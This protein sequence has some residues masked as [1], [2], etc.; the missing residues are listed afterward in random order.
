MQGTA[1]PVDDA[2]AD[3]RGFERVLTEWD[4]ELFGVDVHLRTITRD[5]WVCT[6]Y[7]PGYVHDGTEGEL[8]D[9]ADDPL[10]QVNRWDDPSA[11]P[12]CVPTCSP[13]SGTTSH[14]CTNRCAGW[15]RR[16]QEV[17]LVTP[18]WWASQQPAAL[19]GDLQLLEPRRRLV[20]TALTPH[21]RS[22]LGLVEALGH[23]FEVPTEALGDDRVVDGC[24]RVVATEYYCKQLR[25]LLIIWLLIIRLL[26]IGHRLSSHLSLEF[27]RL[28][29]LRRSEENLRCQPYRRNAPRPVNATLAGR[30]QAALM[31]SYD[32]LVIGGGIAGAS[33]GYELAADRSVGLLE[34]E[35]TLAYHTT[36]RSVAT[37][38]ES[39][40]GRTIRLLTTASRSFM[41]DPPD[42]FGRPLLKPLPLIWV[43]PAC[44]CSTTCSRCTRPSW[45]RYPTCSVLTADEAVEVTKVIRPD[46][47]A[48]GLLEPG[49]SEIDVA[50]LH[51]GYAGGLRARG[52]DIHTSA[53]VAEMRRL[54]DRWEVTDRAGN[55]YD[56]SVVV[57]AAGSWCDVVAAMAGV[58]PVG[59]HPL[60]TNRVHDRSA[61]P[62]DSHAIP[63]V[64]DV[65]GTFYMK[66]EGPQILCSPADEVPSSHATHG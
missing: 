37:F 51:G 19:H 12:R 25:H 31:K 64:A 15:R 26:S 50:A 62:L 35:S 22:L 5:G 21:E 40:G 1:L 11:R 24:S 23:G 66:P 63:L 45:N 7:Q 57:N 3:A 42:G 56:A 38:L 9:L 59:I 30:W 16:S 61:R 20:A 18:C 48:G 60:R 6:A 54:D 55:T 34:M 10:Q 49:A 52:G 47:V 44:R 53:G 13:T 2:D 41:E 46:W 14:R 8:Y 43:A 65:R 36:G 32:V 17:G 4:S 29:R 58:R 28:V 33:I 39:Y 27:L